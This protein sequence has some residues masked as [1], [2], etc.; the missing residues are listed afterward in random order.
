[1]ITAAAHRFLHERLAPVVTAAGWTW[2]PPGGSS[3]PRLFDGLAWGGASFPYVVIQILSPGNDR[4][5]QDG[6][7]IWSDPLYLVKAVTEG[8]DTEDIEPVVD[9][10]DAALHNTRGSMAGARV[11]ECWRERRHEQPELTDGRFYINCGAEYRLR[12]QEA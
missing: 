12:L 5:T 1:M 2:T 3:E 4:H 6:S 8:T 11:V 7:D 9:A 10:I